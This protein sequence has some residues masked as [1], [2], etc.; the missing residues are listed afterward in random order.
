MRLALFLRLVFQRVT[1]IFHLVFNLFKKMLHNTFGLFSILFSFSGHAF[2][3]LLSSSNVSL[4]L[5]FRLSNLSAE[6][7]HFPGC[8]HG[9]VGTLLNGLHHILRL[10]L[11]RS[12]Q[13]AVLF[14]HFLRL[15]IGQLL[16]V[17]GQLLQ[18]LGSHVGVG[19]FGEAPQLFLKG[20]QHGV[21]LIAEILL[22]LVLDLACDVV[23][24]IGFVGGLLD[25]LQPFLQLL[26]GFIPFLQGLFIVVDGL[27]QRFLWRQGGLCHDLTNES[28]KEQRSHGGQEAAESGSCGAKTA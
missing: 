6:V 13:V 1:A 10:V 27:L 14:L 7:F 8:L 25:A 18:L 26:Q 21:F 11:L 20:R 28:R 2:R 3:G 23:C 19:G 9:H 16:N 4:V 5:G 17:L 22:C 12:S 15:L 24:L